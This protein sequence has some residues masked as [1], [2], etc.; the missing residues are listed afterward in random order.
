MDYK[1]GQ[2]GIRGL[3][4]CARFDDF[5]IVSKYASIKKNDKIPENFQLKQN[6]PNPFNNST[7]IEY[8]LPES[9]FVTLRVYSLTGQIIEE[10]VAGK[11]RAG[12]HNIRFSSDSLASGVYL[13]KLNFNQQELNAKMLLVK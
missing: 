1:K 3:E 2:I 5:T 12:W 13:Y 6:F 7:Q 8:Y 11:K 9:G 4:S 10:L